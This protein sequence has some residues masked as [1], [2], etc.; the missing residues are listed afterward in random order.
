MVNCEDVHIKLLHVYR[1]WK[2]ASYLLRPVWCVLLMPKL[3]SQQAHLGSSSICKEQGREALAKTLFLLNIWEMV[4]YFHDMKD[5][6][7]KQALMTAS[8]LQF[9]GVN[10]STSYVKEAVLVILSQASSLLYYCDVYRTN[11]QS[12]PFISLRNCQKHFK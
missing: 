7:V 5:N 4:D 8:Y 2:H 10:K 1:V 3:D 9:H 6:N 12:P 11:M